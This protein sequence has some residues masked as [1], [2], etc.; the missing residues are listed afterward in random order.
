MQ[1]R[2]PNQSGTESEVRSQYSTKRREIN[3]R[4]GASPL[5]SAATAPSWVPPRLA[6]AREPR[7]CYSRR[8]ARFAVDPNANA[9]AVV[10]YSRGLRDPNSLRSNR[11]PPFLPL[12]APDR[13][14]LLAFLPVWHLWHLW[15]FCH[16]LP[17]WHLWHFCSS[18]LPLDKSEHMSYTAVN[19]SFPHLN[20]PAQHQSSALRG[21]RFVDPQRSRARQ[22]SRGP[23]LTGLTLSPGLPAAFHSRTPHDRPEK[24]RRDFHP[25]R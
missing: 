10:P 14:A 13:L 4:G 11:L 8:F 12:S 6:T 18:P 20:I 19:I 23:P 24:P 16:L 3:L 21:R 1:L 9:A 25:A 22:R 17:V 2:G 5:Q 7:S 15:Q